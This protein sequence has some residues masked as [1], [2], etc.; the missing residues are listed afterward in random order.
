MTGTAMQ[1]IR[2]RLEALARARRTHGALLDERRTRETAFQEANEPLLTSLAAAAGVVEQEEAAVRAMGLAL[3]TET[4]EKKP[5]PGVS[6]AVRTTFDYPTAEALAW[7]KVTGIALVP[8]T[9][10]VRTFA[11]V[12]AAMPEKP[13]FVKVV[14]TPQAQIAT[15]LERALAGAAANDPATNPERLKR[16]STHDVMNDFPEVAP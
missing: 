11:K 10:D 1:T 4:G 13:A 6:I 15:D 5:C 7:A 12:I 8:E 3:Y 2:E 16:R 14:E 9:L